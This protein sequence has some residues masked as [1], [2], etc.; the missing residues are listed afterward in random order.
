MSKVSISICLLFLLVL[1]LNFEDWLTDSPTQT[2]DK[3]E[4]A[5]R[6]NYQANKMQSTLYDKQGEIHHQV[7][8]EHMEHYQLLGFTLFEQP[9]YTIFTTAQERPWHVS[10]VEGTLYDDNRLHLE[11]NVVLQSTDKEGFIQT[12]KT[13]FIEIDLN[14]NTLS[15]DQLVTISGKNFV[16][17]GTGF[18]A[19][20]NKR[21][22]ELLNHAK[23]TFS[24]NLSH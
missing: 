14:N 22:F 18:T 3:T 24:P 4:E 5:W 9:Q 12:M 2:T 7:Y 19:N 6:P 16:V 15:S 21:T 11:D 8:A 20:L 1:V 17:Q 13:D 23:S 10:A